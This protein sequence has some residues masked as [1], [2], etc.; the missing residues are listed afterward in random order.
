MTKLQETFLLTP[1][2]IDK[3]SEVF[4]SACKELKVD[5][6]E[7]IRQRFAF[8][9]ALMIW[10]SSF[11]EDQ[12]FELVTYTKLLTPYIA[13]RCINEKS[14]NP[15]VSAAN[16]SY[17]ASLLN[18]LS[19]EP[20]YFFSKGINNAVFQLP[21][22]EINPMAQLGMIILVSVVIGLVG[23]YLIPSDT[24]GTIVQYFI[25]PVYNT[26]LNVLGCIA[27]PL[28]F[29]SVAWGIYGIG[30][31]ATFE[32][33][34]KSLMGH[35]VLC[36]VIGSFF[37]VCTFPLFGLSLSNTGTDYSQMFGLLQII[38]NL[39]PSNIVEPFATGNTLQII[40]LAIIMGIALLYLGKRSEAIA[41]AI[42]QLNSIVNFALS[43]IGKMVPAFVA[44][45]FINI[46]WS[47]KLG[48]VAKIWKLAVFDLG[49]FL[50]CCSAFTICTAALL[51][52]KPSRLAKK[53]L[54]AAIVA[55]STASS[56]AS[57]EPLVTAC[58][59]KIG[60]SESITKFGIPLGIVVSKVIV[61][62][63]YVLAALYITN[64]EGI[65]ISIGWLIILAVVSAITAIATP[66][67]PG[68]SSIAFTL[69]FSQLGLP[70]E[71]LGVILGLDMIVDFFTTGCN[72]YCIP[73][74]LSTVANRFGLINREILEK[75]N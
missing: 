35:Y 67:I 52:V 2:N 31:A 23:M 51:R 5:K 69:L 72:V 70:L 59:D 17:S 27:G 57:F 9:E 73:L 60:V 43:I 71:N 50:I 24:L 74:A 62:L 12:E 25:E 19:N 64:I 54:P 37:A 3:A 58:K 41:N 28:I 44:L 18:I 29:L 38:L 1:E 10:Q 21:K 7:A 6:K 20:E 39:F 66:P 53:V 22:P 49:A 32:K 26:F 48:I 36:V 68:G 42:D 15:F 11:G 45:V 56:A 8:E 34:G 61:S 30:D 16:D 40:V 75:D 55:F 33:L 47:G 65:E 63:E 13:I 14:V 4:V 46:I